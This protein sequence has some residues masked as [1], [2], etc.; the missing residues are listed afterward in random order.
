MAAEPK[1][2]EEVT[3]AMAATSIDDSKP[4]P[5]ATT[6]TSATAKAGTDP[7]PKTVS[8]EPEKPETTPTSSESNEPAAPIAASPAVPEKDVKPTTEAPTS[9]LSKLIAEL[10]SIVKEAEYKEMWGVQLKDESDVPTT[11]VLEKFL[12]ANSKDVTKAKSQLKEALV[13]RKK[14]DP[15]K[16]L[17]ETKFDRSKFGDLGYV[18]TYKTEQGKEIITWNI[19]GAVKDKQ[20]TFGNVEE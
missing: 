7:A 6:P 12:R 5:V 10:P 1:T 16:L 2:I 15:V 11:I 9:P 14:M 8:E 13:W 18:T 19:Y 3:P 20:A 17:T 4:E